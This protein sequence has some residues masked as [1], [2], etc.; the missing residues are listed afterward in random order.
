MKKFKQGMFTASIMQIIKES[1]TYLS[2]KK[3]YQIQDEKRLL[4]KEEAD[5]QIR[6]SVS[7]FRAILRYVDK[8]D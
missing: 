3:G 8:I 2:I 1:H 6:N 7:L 5:E 4:S